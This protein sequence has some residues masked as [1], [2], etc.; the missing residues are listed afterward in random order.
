M[1]LA[2]LRRHLSQKSRPNTDR[3]ESGCPLIHPHSAC[4]HLTKK[5]SLSHRGPSIYCERPHL[6]NITRNSYT[7]LGSSHRL[8]WTAIMPYRPTSSSGNV[9]YIFSRPELMSPKTKW[10][11]GGVKIKLLLILF[12]ILWTDVQI[13]GVGQAVEYSRGSSRQIQTTVDISSKAVMGS[14]Y[15]FLHHSLIA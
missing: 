10:R 12:H 2:G 6:F 8:S 15:H 7:N 13:I 11:E 14:L 9:L 4:K 5:T 3:D 1:R